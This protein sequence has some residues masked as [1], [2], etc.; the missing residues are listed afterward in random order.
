MARRLRAPRGRLGATLL[1]TVTLVAGEA[2]A[3]SVADELVREAHSPEAAHEDDLAL[4]RYA[5]ALTLDPT[6]ADAYLGLGALRFRLGDVREAER[7][8]DTGL[9]HVPGLAMAR[10]GRGRVRRALGALREA[11]DD[12]EAYVAATG[13]ASVLRELAGWYA[14]E[15]RPLAQLAVWRRV[16][17]LDEEG[18]GSMATRRDAQVTVRALELIV[19]SAD[20]VRVPGGGAPASAVRRGIARIEGRR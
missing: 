15:G 3:A 8:Y 20:P 12:L 6:Q 9:S 16:L 13:D 17:V 10:L 14:E 5:E 1:V 2:R 18:R 11:D 4:R 7:V 19:G